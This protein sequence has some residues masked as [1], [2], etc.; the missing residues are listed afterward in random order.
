M[1]HLRILT[2]ALTLI[3]FLMLG[4]NQP[5]LAQ[6]KAPQK[7][8]QHMKM[9]QKQ[10]KEPGQKAGMQGMHGSMM[11]G[12][13]KGSEHMSMGMM[14]DPV[15]KALHSYGCPGF[16]LK[17]A[18]KLNLT[19]KQIQTLTNLKLEF[20]KAATKNKADIKIATL[21]IQQA[22]NAD[23]PDFDKVKKAINKI[24]SLEQ[25]LRNNFLNT[26][27]KARKVLTSEQLKTL[28]TLSSDCC[29]G[30]Q[31]GQGMMKMMGH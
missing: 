8:M 15:F 26:I 17:S 20:K 9:M 14:N 10:E 4:F 11:K 1:K 2:S 16:L 18:K 13:M 5:L 12:M 21:D 30:M 22:M 7:G 31:H 23:Q 3:A 25:E 19:E 29:K 27:I 6:E 28:K 24:S